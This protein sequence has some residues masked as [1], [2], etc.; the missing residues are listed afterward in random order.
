MT[1]FELGY[2]M[3]HGWTLEKQ[4]WDLL[5]Q[6]IEGTRWSKT[7][8]GQLYR[9][10]VPRGPGVYVICVKIPYFNQGPFKWLYN[11]IYVGKADKGNLQD[12]FLYH[13]N[14]PK[15]EIVM[16]RQCFGDNLEYW[17]TEARP[18]KIAEIEARLI[19]CFGPPANRIRGHIPARISNPR[20]A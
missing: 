9:D 12:R 19:D 5:P 14:N 1:I 2:I 15:Q 3:R 10:S 7:R 8:L 16:A 6:V 11:V 20:P 18:N 4:E 13:C 17:F